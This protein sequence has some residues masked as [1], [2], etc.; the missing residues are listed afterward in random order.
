LL[1][2]ECFKSR[3]AEEF[4]L[5]L[6]PDLSGAGD[7]VVTA[8]PEAETGQDD[9]RKLAEAIRLNPGQSKER[10]VELSGLPQRRARALLER[11]NGQCW[12][13]EPGRHSA[14]LF[15]PTEVDATNIP[16]SE[17]GA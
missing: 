15:F 13:S 12:R 14:T 4:S 2:L 8:A 3:F 5:T 9:V 7:F 10:V 17:T 1:R 16:L 11:F 6:R